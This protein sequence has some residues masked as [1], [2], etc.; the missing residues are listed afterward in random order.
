MTQAIDFELAGM[1]LKVVVDYEDRAVGGVEMVFAVGQDGREML[2]DC[3]T[4]MFYELL[5][6]ELQDAFEDYLVQEKAYHDDMKWEQAR[7]EG[8][9]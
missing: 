9:L 4:G 2:V 8:R 5:E 7:E 3:D 1:K 6:G